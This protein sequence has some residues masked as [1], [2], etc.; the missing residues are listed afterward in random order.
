MSLIGEMSPIIQEIVSSKDSLNT[1]GIL[2]DEFTQV[3]KAISAIYTKDEI[4]KI[5]L[6]WH[7]ASKNDPIMR[8]T[9]NHVHRDRAIPG[10]YGQTQSESVRRIGFD[11]HH[12]EFL[13][14]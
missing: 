7:L 5:G 3:M 13:Q 1:V 12:H 9:L 2:W 8:Q 14:C 4:H 6:I 11:L 10:V